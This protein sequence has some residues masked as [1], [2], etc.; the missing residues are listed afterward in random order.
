MGYDMNEFI[1]FIKFV[2]F[3]KFRVSFGQGLTAVPA[4]VDKAPHEGAMDFMNLINLT[5]FMN[6]TS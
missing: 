4:T 1:R 2:K 5:N 6:L 3:I